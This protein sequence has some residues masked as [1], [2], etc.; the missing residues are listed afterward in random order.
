MT[1]TSLGSFSTARRLGLIGLLLA[2]GAGCSALRP[3]AVE[4][5]HF[6]S[7]D[8]ARSEAPAGAPNPSTATPTLIVNPP[9]AAAGF[10]SPR[11]VYLREAHQLEYYAHSEWIDSPARMIAPLIVKALSDSGRFRAVVMTPS[12]ADSDLRLDTEIVRLQHELDVHPGVVRFTLRATLVDNR[13]REVLAW[14]EFDEHA[15]APSETPYGGV[16]AANQAVQTVL[17]QLAR[18]CA[19]TPAQWHKP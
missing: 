15:A 10:S 7:L 8:A 19:E 2:L 13:T 18:F 4:Q 17:V 16:L 6:Y 3:A 14:R 12:A 5:P 9:R 1:R 11:I